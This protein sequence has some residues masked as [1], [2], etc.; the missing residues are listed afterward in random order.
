M[1]ERDASQYAKNG[2]EMT[3]I[4]FYKVPRRHGPAATYSAPSFMKAA[5]RGLFTLVAAAMLPISSSAYTTGRLAV[6]SRA[7]TSPRMDAGLHDYEFQLAFAARVAREAGHLLVDP[8]TPELATADALQCLK[9]ELQHEP[10]VSLD[11]KWTWHVDEHI[12]SIALVDAVHGP[13]VGAVCRPWTNE[14]LCAAVGGGTFVQN[15]DSAPQA[16][17]HVGMASKYANII[18]V[19][20][21]KCPEL[22]LALES[23]GEKMPTNVTQV[24]GCCCC[25]GLFEVVSGRADAH[26]SPPEHCYMGQQKTPLP[27]LCAFEVLLSESGGVMTDVFGNE[28]DLTAVDSSHTKGVLASDSSSH[29][30]LLHAIRS[31]FERERLLLPRLADLLKSDAV[32]FKVEHVGGEE[33]IMQDFQE[34]DSAWTFGLGDQVDRLEQLFGEQSDDSEE[35]DEGYWGIGSFGA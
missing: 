22:D 35:S 12:I 32:G 33:R 25:E 1:L 18:H 2:I 27:V 23:I 24:K 14:L 5:M 11:A 30:Y 4:R 31:P 7:L 26:L 17:P 28:I 21:D 16:A 3:Q 20:H 19:P 15:G 13:V 8:T 34:P 6:H 10:A 29:N 9:F